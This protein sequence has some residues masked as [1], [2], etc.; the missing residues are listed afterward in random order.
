MILIRLILSLIA[1][2]LGI[3]FAIPAV[4]AMLPFWIVSAVLKIIRLSGPKIS[5][6][7][8][9]IEYDSKLGWRAKSNVD[10]HMDI[11]GIYRMTTGADGWRGGYDLKES[12][13]LVIGDSFV[14]GQGADDRDHFAN[15]TKRA[16]VKP[17]GAPGY[18]LTHYLLLLQNLT[19]ELKGKLVIWFVHTGNDYR[20]AV[21]P[22]SYGYHF[23]FVFRNA[24][25][26][27][28][29]IRADH[30]REKKLPFHF[31]KGY[32][33]SMPELADLFS[34]NYFSDY[35]FGAFEYLVSEAKKH[36][37]RYGAKFAVVTLPVRWLIDGSYTQKIKR[38]AS[39]PENFSVKYPDE[40]ASLICKRLHIEFRATL[41]EFVREDFL[42]VDLHWSRRGHEKAAK[43]IDE[44]Y[45]DFLKK[46]SSPSAR[47]S[48]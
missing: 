26:G 45:G 38:H 12:D 40:Q 9:I 16:R 10:V 17:L 5:D 35:G 23:P 20:E 34:K 1:F 37:A 14:F 30:I 15:L 6:W 4:L 21:R 48:A 33:T 47:Q 29:Q 41:D 27:A 3:I 39:A 18:G 22:S 36:C 43:I 11:D 7:E 46:W 8:D 24:E 28:W 25:T 42:P 2:L 44:L 32:N 19:S 31:E 13:T